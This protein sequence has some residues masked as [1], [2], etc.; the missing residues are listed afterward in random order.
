LSA[1]QW[2]SARHPYGNHLESNGF[3]SDRRRS[4]ARSICL[5]DD[6]MQK[7]HP[8]GFALF[9]TQKPASCN[10]EHCESREESC[11]MCNVSSARVGS[12]TTWR[13]RHNWFPTPDLQRCIRENDFH[14]V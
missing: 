11:S 3:P 10:G 1:H 8:H 14:G 9:Q 6:F 2:W 13:D 7:R 5:M 12:K 4:F